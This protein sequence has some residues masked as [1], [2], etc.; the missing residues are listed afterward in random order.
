MLNKTKVMIGV[1][2]IISGLCILTIH[3]TLNKNKTFTLTEIENDI[4]N[5]IYQSADGKKNVQNVKIETTKKV[6]EY[7][8]YLYSYE[9]KENGVSNNY[10]IYK[11]DQGKYKR[12]TGSILSF[13]FKNSNHNK[14]LQYIM[15][16]GYLILVGIINNGDHDT[17]EIISGD[18]TITDKYER[19]KYFIKEYELGN[20]NTMKI[21]PK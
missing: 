8:V 13:K 10:A 15:K 18:I 21:T 17:Y 1:L 3:N 19:N 9:Y 11:E 20:P 4:V 16:D 7:I 5:R 14:G 2:L 12:D 6:G